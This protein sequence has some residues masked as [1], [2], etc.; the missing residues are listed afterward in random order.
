MA[1]REPNR[2]RSVRPRG[3]LAA[4]VAAAALLL[5]GCGAGAGAGRGAA[6]AG[7]GTASESRPARR[8]EAIRAAEEL[9]RAK[10]AEGVDMSNGP[11]LAQE[12]VPDW[13]VDVAHD[14]RQPVDDL[15]QNQCASYRQGHVH[16]FVELDPQGR[17][18]RAE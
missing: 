12:V 4:L 10:L 13:A 9:F 5:A 2:H 15:P 11:C 6:G 1:G 17:L 3:V 18:I 14:P 16:H 7:T 8:A